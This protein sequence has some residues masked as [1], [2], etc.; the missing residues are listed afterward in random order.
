M[1]PDIASLSYCRVELGAVSKLLRTEVF[2]N[3]PNARFHVFAVQMERFA[4]AVHSPE[5]HVDVWV[6]RVVMRNR[7]PFEMTITQIASHSRHQLAG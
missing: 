6:F 4:L 7:C 2:S 5:R 1:L 3:I